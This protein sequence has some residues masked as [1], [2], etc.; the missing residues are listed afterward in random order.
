MY[1]Y[2]IICTVL[3]LIH[4]HRYCIDVIPY[5]SDSGIILHYHNIS[6]TSSKYYYLNYQNMYYKFEVSVEF[7]IVCLLTP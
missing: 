5:F 7:R 3:L 6:E 2:Y 4:F 1:L